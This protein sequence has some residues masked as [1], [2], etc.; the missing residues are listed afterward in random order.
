MVLALIA[1]KDKDKGS[2]FTRSE[3]LSFKSTREVCVTAVRPFS[4]RDRGEVRERRGVHTKGNFRAIR[5]CAK[6]GGIGLPTKYIILLRY[7]SGL[8]TGRVFRRRKTRGR[9]ISRIAG[10]V[11]GLLRRTTRIIVIAG[12][13]FSSTIIFSKSVSSC[14]RCLKGVGRTTTRETSRIIRIVC[15]VPIFRGST[16]AYDGLYG[17]CV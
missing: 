15:K 13:V 9:A 2:T 16:S 7:V 11:R 3:I 12:R 4:R 10:K 6:L 17:W 8:I 1:K 14:L 5:Y